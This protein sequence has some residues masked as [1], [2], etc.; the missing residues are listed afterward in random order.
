MHVKGMLTIS[1]T[2]ATSTAANN[3]KTKVIN[4]NCSPFTDCTNEVNNT[5]VDNAKDIDIVMSIY[6]LIEYSDNYSK[7]SG[8][9]WQCYRDE[10]ALNNSGGIINFS[11]N[12]NNSPT[13]NFK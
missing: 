7:T 5:Q 12:A 3:A 2:E 4:K 1:N 8:T 9:L 6:N 13:I 10:P 11:N